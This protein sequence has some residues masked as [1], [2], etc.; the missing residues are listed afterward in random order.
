MLGQDG[1]LTTRIG[2]KPS[3]KTDWRE[4]SK[5]PF[6]E[7]QSGWISLGD[8]Y[9]LFPNA[10]LPQFDS[11]SARAFAAEDRLDATAALFALICAGP[12]PPRLAL[13][14][15]LKEEPEPGCIRLVDHG[16]CPWPPLRRHVIAAL[17]AQ[18]RGERLGTGEAL[19]PGLI[20]R[21]VVVPVVEA[22]E[23]LSRR[24]LAHRAIRPDNFYWADERRQA[25][26]LGECVTS[27]PGHDQPASFE[28]VENALTHPAGRS[29]GTVADDLFALGMTVLALCRRNPS[30][31]EGGTYEAVL[32]RL[33]QG[34]TAIPG[35][36]GAP[37][38]ELMPLL[39]GL[40]S[41]APDQR[42]GLDELGSWL[43]GQPALRPPPSGS[44][45]ALRPLRFGDAHYRTPRSLAL[46]LSA[47]VPAAAAAIRSGEVER[48]AR[49]D[50]RDEKL[51]DA[52][53]A[54]RRSLARFGRQNQ[55]A[56][57]AAVA[58]ACAL[59]DPSGPLRFGKLALMP[60]SIGTAAY[61]LAASGK[62][63]DDLIQMLGA[64]FPFW[65]PAAGAQEPAGIWGPVGRLRSWLARPGLGSG[66]ERFLYEVNPG[67]PCLGAI[68][69]AA[70]VTSLEMLAAQLEDNARAADFETS[71]IDAH[72]A[73]FAAAH[74][75]ARQ[76]AV[77][78][79]DMPDG[80]RAQRP[81]LE[82]RLLAAVQHAAGDPCLPLLSRWMAH[83]VKPLVAGLHNRSTRKLLIAELD[84][85]RESGRL[86][87][88]AG[89]LDDPQLWQADEGGF[90]AARERF[91]RNQLALARLDTDRDALLAAAREQGRR[92]AAALALLLLAL[93][94][95]GTL[96]AQI[97]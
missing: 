41:D 27:P 18:P 83:R 40:L 35:G 65:L 20:V 14:D 72:V 58:Q 78:R 5:A 85:R 2:M 29:T 26:L 13:M 21:R 11:P 66:F 71:P 90:A 67:L 45:A 63:L 76:A 4:T 12:A 9:R 43:R 33:E 7:E 22:L 52:L 56:N 74:L 93:A 94:G 57:E 96:L 92:A 46:G 37:P 79:L 62:P 97:R 54:M 30:P 1:S 91:R 50:M 59:L 47:N 34:A 68:V 8:R 49:E 87:D 75:A 23:R 77:P 10:P 61:T 48:W 64:E 17:F 53:A 36:D 86:S 28:S 42:W 15:R 81:M 24:G 70:C 88:I 19:P 60:E 3:V 84:R 73:G 44:A 6:P 31:P 89:L 95:A 25:V 39:R 82:L 16:R 80:Q 55:R 32:R 69:G 38:P 51:A